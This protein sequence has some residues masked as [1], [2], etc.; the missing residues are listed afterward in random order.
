MFSWPT[1]AHSMLKPINPNE[2]QVDNEGGIINSGQSTSNEDIFNTVNTLVEQ[3]TPAALDWGTKGITVIF[4]AAVLLMIMAIIFKNGQWQ[5]F[6]QSSMLWSFI[7]MM[8]IRAIPLTILSIQGGMDVDDAFNTMIAGLTQLSLFLGVTGIMLSFL[9]R[10]IH[11]L[12]K[13]PEYHR[14]SKNVFSMSLLMM[15]FALVGPLLFSVL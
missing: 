13:H 6:A 2:I 4:I 7:A 12:I 14:W 3:G 10:F 8:V 9:F 1:L 15:L 11:K 5:K